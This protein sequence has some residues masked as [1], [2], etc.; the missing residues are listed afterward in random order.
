MDEMMG[1]DLLIS[2]C[3]LLRPDLTVEAGMSLAVSAGRIAAI[4]PAA[5]LDR[6]YRAHE[7]LD[8][9]GKLAIPGL[10]DAHTH[11]VQ[12]LLRGGVVDERPMIWARILLPYED[13]LRPDTIYHAALLSCLEMIKAGIT[14][15]VDNGSRDMVPVI[16][17]TQEAGMRAVISRMTRDYG[18][19]VLPSMKETTAQALARSEALY[20]EYHGS[21]Q[22]R[23]RVAFSVT[24]PMASTPELLDG[25]AELSRKY[26]T[27]VHCHLAEHL[28]EVE[29][30]MTAHRLRPA[31]YFEAHGLLG[32][33]LLAAH[34]VQL[35]DRELLLMAE[36]DV[37]P[38]L[39]PMSNLTN[40]GFPKATQMLAQG[41]T[42]SAASDGAACGAIDLFGAIRLLKYAM[43]ARYGLPVSDYAALRMGDVF[44]MITGNAAR[45]IQWDDE[46]GSLEVG[47]KADIVL[48]NWMQPHLYPTRD[49]FQTL[50]M[51]AGPRDVSDTIID[52]QLLL[53]DRRFTRL[54]EAEIMARAAEHLATLMR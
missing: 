32:S 28:R 13:R 54:D 38:V 45:A 21:A 15:F 50:V 16:Q 43:Q 29:A 2:D 46:I 40:H 36:R 25:V 20:K 41:M 48:L 12:Q 52:G 27:I 49:I 24:N 53:R 22:G 34:T 47:K 7:T 8:G 37:K 44:A 39:C 17:A 26:G 42:V 19:E 9:S 6:R 23:V 31:E 11:T 30:C 51:A 33:N 4:A 10:I 1:C 18:Q 3:W 5:E 14:T 35:T